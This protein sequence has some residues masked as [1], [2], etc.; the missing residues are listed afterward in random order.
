MPKL[1]DALLPVGLRDILAP[2]AFFK[3]ELGYKF[4]KFFHEQNYQQINP[5][6][7]E[8]ESAFADHHLTNNADLFRFNDPVSQ[9]MLA[10]RPDMTPQIARIAAHIFDGTNSLRLS[11][12]GEVFRAQHHQLFPTRQLTQMGIEFIGNHE[13][14]SDLEVISLAYMFL[15]TITDETIILDLHC[16]ELV[17]HIIH[18]YGDH[19]EVIN[20]IYHKDASYFKENHDVIKIL[21]QAIGNGDEVLMRLLSTKELAAFHNILEKHLQLCQALHKQYK[22]LEITFDALESRSFSYHKHL[23]FTFYAKESQKELGCGGHYMIE[24]KL[25]ASGVTFYVDSLGQLGTRN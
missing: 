8:F 15:Q 18:Q 12:L 17:A 13:D 11:Y 23:T 25:E 7:I 22:G 5:P 2:Q 4:L 3:T 16:P 20:A 9:E 24:N 19:N 10:L 6:C 14:V 21:F 1:R